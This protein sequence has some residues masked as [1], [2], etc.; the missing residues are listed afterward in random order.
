MLQYLGME[1]K[2]K[3]P[4]ERESPE[5]VHFTLPISEAPEL[6]LLLSHQEITGV[7]VYPGYGGRQ[8][9]SL[10]QGISKFTK[11]RVTFDITSGPWP[12]KI[13]NHEKDYRSIQLVC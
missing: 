12:D 10:K 8:G 11:I 1:T 7:T 4:K 6:L 9:L 13:I 5:L 2:E 3:A